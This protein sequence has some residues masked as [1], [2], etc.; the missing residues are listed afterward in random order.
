MN[1]KIILGIIAILV[2]SLIGVGIFRQVNIK[3][4]KVGLKIGAILPLTGKFSYYGNEV[5]NALTIAQP[6]DSS[7]QFVFEDNLSQA[8][9][10]VTVANKLFQNQNI[11]LIISS[12][13]PLSLPL[14]PI[15][16]SYK[17]VLLA[18]V[19]GAK[20]FGLE[21]EWCFRDA[22]NQD[23]EGVA[24]AQY[25]INSNFRKVAILV[26]NDD[27]GLS[28]AKAFETK[29]EEMG[30]KIVGKETFEM[31]TTD[32]KNLVSKTLSTRPEI[33]L[34]IGREQTIITAINQIRN[35][36]PII[37]IIT[38]DSFESENVLKG[39]GK[40]AKGIVFTSYRNNLS[41][42]EASNFINSYKNNFKTNPGIYAFDA[43]IAGNYIIDIV[44]KSNSPDSIRV[45]LSKLV[46]YSQIKGKLK[47]D[48]KRNIVS[49]MA[50]YKINDNLQKEEI[51]IIE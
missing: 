16:G 8:T 10:A 13:S 28:G 15:A 22:I 32:L 29:F 17:K 27:Y 44:K 43:F 36:N 34:T 33:I 24:Q 3:Q 11:S 9:N 45:K 1:K 18:L 38:S 50:V 12:N 19:T 7:I 2:L 47:I 6:K 48:D 4:E 51:T 21:N 40:N 31:N 42:E 25:V 30:G 20:D 49:P 39:L 46:Y 23:Q 26:V 41:T 35:N 14:R 37:P 5:K